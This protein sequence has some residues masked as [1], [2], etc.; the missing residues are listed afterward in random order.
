M[1][2][3]KNQ[4]TVQALKTLPRLPTIDNEKPS[5]THNQ[6]FLHMSVASSPSIEDRCQIVVTPVAS[7]SSV[8]VRLKQFPQKLSTA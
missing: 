8:F 1:G 5:P 2:L 4:G 7:D 6:D 3:H